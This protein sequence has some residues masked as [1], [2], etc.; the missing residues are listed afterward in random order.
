MMLITWLC[1]HVEGPVPNYRANRVVILS[2]WSQSKG[3]SIWL[4]LVKMLRRCIVQ[5]IVLTGGCAT[6]LSTVF[7]VLFC[8][9]S[10]SSMTEHRSVLFLHRKKILRSTSKSVYGWEASRIEARRGMN[11]QWT[12]AMKL[13][14]G[15]PRTSRP[16]YIP[17]IITEPVN[18]VRYITSWG[19][20]QVFTDIPPYKRT[21][22]LLAYHHRVRFPL[23]AA[24]LLSQNIYRSAKKTR[25]FSP[26]YT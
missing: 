11:H 3:C 22:S 25:P 4:Y 20:T 16:H 8:F 5:P 6:V 19:Q 23:N 7:V 2:K 13:L 26:C 15:A 10:T 12:G 9:P 1:V 14:N 21:G 18:C 24:P 17:G